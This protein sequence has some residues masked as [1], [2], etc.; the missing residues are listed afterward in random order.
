[1]VGS[2]TQKSTQLKRI[3]I[4]P[5]LPES[6]APLG[7]LAQNLWWSWDH[8]ATDMFRNIDPAEFE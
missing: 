7:A 3:F 5:K 6:L 1:M 8:E 2:L 4:E